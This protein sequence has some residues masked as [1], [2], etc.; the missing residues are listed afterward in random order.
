MANTFPPTA[1]TTLTK[2]LP[3]YLYQE[4]SDDD[5]LQAFVAAYNTLAQQFVDFFVSIGLPVYTG[6]AIVGSL[7]DWVGQGLYGLARPTLSSGRNQNFGPFNTAQFNTLTLNGLKVTGSPNVAATSDDIYK[8]ILTWHLYKGDG[9]VFNI[10]W[11]KRRIMRF[12]SGI[13][14]VDGLFSNTYQVSITYGPQPLSQMSI[15]IIAGRRTFASGALLDSFALNTVTP[16]SFKTNYQA[17]TPF[18]VAAILQQA[19]NSGALEL[20]F[21]LL[22]PIVTI[23]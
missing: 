22:N 20:P 19:I 15:R 8:R 16:G 14:G 2:T 7:L 5:D 18:P 11:L 6:P 21:Q 17:Q 9:K 13:N 10:M 12:L 4:Y 3:A 1:P 23:V